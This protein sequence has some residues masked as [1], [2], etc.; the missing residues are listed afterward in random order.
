VGSV[1]GGTIKNETVPTP[2]YSQK[3]YE[4]CIKL[5]TFERYSSMYLKQ[6]ERMNTTIII[7]RPNGP[8]TGK[9]EV[10][11][12]SKQAKAEEKERVKQAR[13]MLIV[14]KSLAKEYTKN[15]KVEE[16]ERV[17][18]EKVEEKERVKKEKVEEKERVKKANVEAKV[19]EKERVK[20]AKVEEKERVKKAKIEEKERVKKAKVEENERVKQAKK[21]E[22]LRVKEAKRAERAAAVVAAKMRRERVREIRLQ[23]NLQA[24]RTLR[25]F[26]IHRAEDRYRVLR[27]EARQIVT[28]A[29]DL[30]VARRDDLRMRAEDGVFWVREDN[31]RWVRTAQTEI[32]EPINTLHVRMRAIDREIEE[33]RLSGNLTNIRPSTRRERL[34]HRDQQQQQQQQRQRQE[35]QRQQREYQHQREYQQRQYRPRQRAVN[36]IQELITQDNIDCNKKQGELIQSK[37]AIETDSC[38]ICFEDIDSNTNKM[39][40]RCG[41]QFCGDCIITHMQCIGGLKCPLC[42][43]QYGVRIAGWKPPEKR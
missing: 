24:M 29:R 11:K 20:K 35:I 26:Q 3:V 5:R 13:Q 12:Q 23:H 41:H 10:V 8:S 15:K 28:T 25:I 16:K 30:R 22:Q 38:P 42:R 33:L 7:S 37:T 17:K 4:K 32:D 19:E 18:K 9:M 40:L 31:G 39:I 43:E 14:R 1:D 6:F 21:A 2:K 34:E 36:P 27:E